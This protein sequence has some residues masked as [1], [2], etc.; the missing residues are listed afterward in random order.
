MR[1]STVASFKM[2]EGF[3]YVDMELKKVHNPVARSLRDEDYTLEEKKIP[4]WF[5]IL[6]HNKIL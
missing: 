2:I 3:E 1:F 6:H 4:L 5:G